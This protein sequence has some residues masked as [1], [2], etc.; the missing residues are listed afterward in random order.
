MREKKKKKDEEINVAKGGQ[1]E[2]IIYMMWLS[3][4][5]KTKRQGR[6]G[7]RGTGRVVEL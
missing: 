2:K 4:G 3:F 5:G 1:R 7:G 6:G